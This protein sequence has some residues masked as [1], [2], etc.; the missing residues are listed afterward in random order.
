MKELTQ[1]EIEKF[2]KSYW[3]DKSNMELTQKLQQNSIS[4]IAFIEKKAASQLFEFSIEIPTVKAV[5]QGNAGR[6]WIVAGLNLMMIK[7]VEMSCSCGMTAVLI[8][9]KSLVFH[10][11]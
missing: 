5:S 1:K 6:C 2:K 9:K 11:K 4:D 10:L 8:M 7:C 3:N